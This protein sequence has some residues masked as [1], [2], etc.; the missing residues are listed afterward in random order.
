[1]TPFQSILFNLLS[2]SV[3]GQVAERKWLQQANRGDK[4]GLN[5]K[6]S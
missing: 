3:L 1:M 6:G 4:A 2:I 5:K